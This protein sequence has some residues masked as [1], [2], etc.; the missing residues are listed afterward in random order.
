MSFIMSLMSLITA[1][2]RSC[3]KVMFSLV[4]FFHGAPCDHYPWSILPQCTGP[5]LAPA[6]WQAGVHIILECF[7][8]LLPPANEVCEGYVFTPVCQS[9]CSQG[10]SVHGRGCACMAGGVCGRGCAWQGVCVHGRGCAWQGGGTCVA[11]GM[12][13]V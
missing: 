4:S 6:S 13:I 5:S 11:G 1:R 9:F 12:C 7:L 8:V 10:A 3:G 2:Q